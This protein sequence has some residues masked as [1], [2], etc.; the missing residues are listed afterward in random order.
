[1]TGDPHPS[2]YKSTEKCNEEI[3]AFDAFF[4]FSVIASS[5]V[6]CKNV[7][8]KAE[9]RVDDERGWWFVSS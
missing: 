3:D 4:F 2:L 8:T 7:A 1:M 5:P 9:S 6:F